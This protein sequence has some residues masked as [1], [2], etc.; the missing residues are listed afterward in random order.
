MVRTPLCVNQEVV[1]RNGR[2]ANPAMQLLTYHR[3]HDA[4]SR[5]IP[6]V[7]RALGLDRYW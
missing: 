7:V 2:K 4:N 5:G 1:D 6:S 3:I